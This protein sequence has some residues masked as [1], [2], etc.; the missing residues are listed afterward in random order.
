MPTVHTDSEGRR[1]IIRHRGP[2]GKGF[3]AGG[4]TGQILAK[5]ANTDYAATWVNPPDGTDAIT[6][7]VA[8]VDGNLAV[9]NGTTG[10]Q[11]RDSGVALSGLASASALASKVD[12]EL[13][14]GLS[15][16]DFSNAY[17]LKLD[18]LQNT[19]GFRGTFASLEAINANSFDPVPV[20]GDYCLIEV[21]DA[22]PSLVLW[23]DTNDEW[24]NQFPDAVNMTG[25]QIA[26]VLFDADDTWVIDDCRIFTE[27]YRA[28]VDQHEALI[29]SLTGVTVDAAQ[30]NVSYFSLVGVILTPPAASDGVTNLI[31]VDV[32]TSLSG[33]ASGFDNGGSNGRLRYTGNTTRQFLVSAKV[34]LSGAINDTLVLAFA[35]NGSTILSSRVLHAQDAAGSVTT[36]TLT[37]VV[38]LALND[39]VEVVVGNV[40]DSIPVTVQV[41][42]IDAAVV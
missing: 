14:K 19:A 37:S 2:A 8:A 18:S 24:V 23:D 21:E 10:K 20:S 42:S 36:V 6:G 16:H 9:F 3:P 11:L 31:K 7:P 26:E 39:H 15:T 17:K 4:T 29:A 27:A 5:T 22:S 35:K 33:S 25:E 13:N 38:Q 32:P 41:L 40:T 12:K 28:K 1:V 30:G 34:S